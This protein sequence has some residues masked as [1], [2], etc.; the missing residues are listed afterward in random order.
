M[1]RLCNLLLNW[2]KIKTLRKK[3]SLWRLVAR[4]VIQLGRQKSEKSK[5]GS[6]SG[7]SDLHHHWLK[8]AFFLMFFLGKSLESKEW[9]SPAGSQLQCDLKR[10]HQLLFRR[11]WTKYRNIRLWLLWHICA[12]NAGAQC[13]WGWTAWAVNSAMWWLI[14]NVFQISPNMLSAHKEEYRSPALLP[15]HQQRY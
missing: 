7:W 1:A 3:R 8:T 15:Q 11:E 4:M 13:Q 5:G 6:Q 10:Y 2:R 12:T 14:G 9:K